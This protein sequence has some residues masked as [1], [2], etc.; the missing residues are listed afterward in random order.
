MLPLCFRHSVL[1][2]CNMTKRKIIANDLAAILFD[3]DSSESNFDDSVDDMDRD[4]LLL[5]NERNYEDDEN[6]AAEDESD[7][8]DEENDAAEEAEPILAMDDSV[9]AAPITNDSIEDEEMPSD[10]RDVSIIISNDCWTDFVG[11]QQPFAFSGQVGLLKPVSPDSFPLDVFS[12]LVDENIIRHTV[13]ET[14][15]YATQTLANRSLPK[16]SRINKWV[17]T[18]QKEIK[19]FLAK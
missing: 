14:N 6:D 12:P 13:A 4:L 7:Y 8:E 16:F 9:V 10:D 15:K 3:S 18:D 2:Y 17:E 11:R 5:S 1:N 19:N